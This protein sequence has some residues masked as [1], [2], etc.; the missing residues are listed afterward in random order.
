MASTRN[1]RSLKQRDE[2]RAFR[3]FADVAGLNLKMR[4]LRSP[5]EPKPD[6]SCRVDGVPVFFELTR[7]RHLGSANAMGRHVSE[8]GRGLQSAPPGVDTY[9]DRAALKDALDRKAKKHYDTGIRP[10]CLLI[11]IDGVF[12]PSG[13][14][15]SWARPI[16]AA[17]GPHSRWREIWLFDEA[18]N[19]VI[20]C[21]RQSE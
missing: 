21:W 10:I 2:R 9:D 7:M 14:P 6:I 11:R 12:H 16:L 3:R 19:T 13:M 17:V 1:R 8:L 4:S 15:A 5:E 20:A 18:R